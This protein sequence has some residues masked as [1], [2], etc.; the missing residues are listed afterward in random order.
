MQVQ[1]DGDNLIPFAK[2]SRVVSR[3]PLC[4]LPSQ[5]HSPVPQYYGDNFWENLSQ[6]PSPKW[7]EEQYIPPILKGT[8]CSKPG[9][10]PVEG[11]PPPERL[12]RRKRRK[13]E[14]MQ[15][16]PGNVPARVRAVT[17]HLEDLRRRQRNMDELKKAQ[18]G[19]SGAASEPPVL[20]EEGCG[21]PSTTEYADLEKE[22]T[23][24]PQE[25]NHFVTPAR[26]QLLWSPW[27]PL[28]TCTY[29]RLSSRAYSTVTAR[30]NPTYNPWRMELESEE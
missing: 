10:Y 9:L 13:L 8:G 23:T 5:S 28:G 18:W 3:Y 2:S 12:W 14:R 30:R 27:S 4:S 16:G 20:E 24:C 1:E 25:E 7:M 6:R 22:R 29:G 11:L 21:F 15:Q 19:S 17:Y 26:A